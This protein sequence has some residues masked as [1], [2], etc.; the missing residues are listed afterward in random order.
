MKA[1]TGPWSVDGF[2]LTSVIKNEGN[3]SFPQW[4]HIARCDYGYSHPESHL[5]QNKANAKLIAA[6]PDMLHALQEAYKEL[7]FHNWNNTTTG[8]LIDRV[9]KQATE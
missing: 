6:A 8:N 7:C 4:K 1:T 5:E 9:I 3:E 2:D